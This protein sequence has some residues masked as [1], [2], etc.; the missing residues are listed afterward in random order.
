MTTYFW[1]MDHTI[2]DN[3]CDV[4]WK[5][6]LV[7][8]GLAGPEQLEL[9]DE[10]YRQYERGELKVDEYLEFQLAEFAGCSQAKVEELCGRH[11]EDVVKHTFYPK[12]VKMLEDQ[13]L[14]GGTRILLT[15]TNREIAR[16]LSERL[17]MDDVI[18]SELEM[19]NGVFTGRPTGVYCCGEGK[20]SRLEAYCR[21]NGIDLSTVHYYGDSISDRYVLEI[22]GYPHVVNPMPALRELA[23]EQ[24]W[25][26]LDFKDGD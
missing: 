20:A 16:P 26:I 13:R 22:V 7:N 10:F 15:A 19:T 24:R 2:I 17:E 11:F 18:A 6:F 4:S 14:A 21:H 12:A 8:E 9:A 1:D 5:Q 25:D 3:D 23:L